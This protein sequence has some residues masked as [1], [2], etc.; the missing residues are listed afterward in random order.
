MNVGFMNKYLNKIPPM[1]NMSSPPI[2]SLHVYTINT[3]FKHKKQC[4]CL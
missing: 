1:I 2:L 4:R 3:V